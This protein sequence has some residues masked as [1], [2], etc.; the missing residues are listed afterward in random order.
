M[1]TL[2]YTEGNRLLQAA[3]GCLFLPLP[4]TRVGGGGLCVGRVG[5]VGSLCAAP[6]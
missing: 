1:G 3:A 2:G 4:L 6:S 5:V